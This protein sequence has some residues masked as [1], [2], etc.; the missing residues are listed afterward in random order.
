MSSGLNVVVGY[1]TG[2]TSIKFC[3]AEFPKR[4]YS[5]DNT[6]LLAACHSILPSNDNLQPL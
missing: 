6:I 4:K 2:I 3:G 1:S 5:R